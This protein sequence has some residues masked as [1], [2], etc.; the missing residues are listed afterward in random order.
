VLA[1]PSIVVVEMAILQV[2]LDAAPESPAI[3][4]L[5]YA[6]LLIVSYCIYS[7]FLH[8]I[9]HIPGPILS[10]VTSLWLCYH[11]YI[12]DEASVIYLLHKRYGTLIRVAPNLVDISDADAI[13]PIYVTC[14]GFSKAAYYRNFDIDGYTTIF[15][16]VD[17]AYR[18][19]RA[20]KVLPMFSA[21]SIR[22]NN[23]AIYDCINRMI[24]R[25]QSDAV[26]SS[27]EYFEFDAFTRR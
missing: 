22:S 25:M 3:A 8:P 24:L 14:G 27:C 13:Q 23:E 4:S 10:K 26:Y 5:A 2:V 18:T 1:L 16:T 7:I 21:A 9:A 15:S 11:S 12:G 20:K 19:L 17:P 6:L